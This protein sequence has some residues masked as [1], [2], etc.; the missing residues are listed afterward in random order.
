VLINTTELA[1]A[2]PQR[3]TM[4]GKRLPS[5]ASAAQP[6]GPAGTPNSFSHDPYPGRHRRQPPA[7]QPVTNGGPSIVDTLPQFSP[8]IIVGSDA[9]TLIGM[10][11]ARPGARP[12]AVTGSTVMYSI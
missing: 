10:P 8:A 6:Q 3:G 9:S 11:A 2:D 7:I 4:I 1:P 12:A 5:P